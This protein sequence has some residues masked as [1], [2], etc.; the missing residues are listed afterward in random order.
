MRA[1]HFYLTGYDWPDAGFRDPF[2]HCIAWELIGELNHETSCGDL[3]A[4]TLA[5]CLAIRSLLRGPTRIIAAYRAQQ[6][7]KRSS[8]EGRVTSREL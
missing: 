2:I 6:S 1:A 7:G 8:F 3:F 5:D 4:E